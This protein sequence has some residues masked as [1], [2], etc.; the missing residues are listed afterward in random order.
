MTEH[1]LQSLI[2]TAMS[3]I[4]EMVDCNTMIGQPIMTPGDTMILPVSRVSFGLGSGG[5]DFPSK[6]PKELFGGGLGAGA[7]ITPIAF[8]VV[9]EGN[10]RLLQLT[11]RDTT[12][13]DRLMN[14]LPDLMDRLQAVL[15][16]E[17]PEGEAAPEA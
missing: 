7:T 3:R 8:L 1:P 12:N 11:D 13:L 15:K 14:A 6:T 4:H 17:K 9:H 16:K 10:V 5:S 2:D